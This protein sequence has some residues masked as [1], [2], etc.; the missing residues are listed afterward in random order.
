MGSL[1][2]YPYLMLRN[3]S[4]ITVSNNPLLSVSADDRDDSTNSSIIDT[5]E[6]AS[7]GLTSV[8]SVL[9]YLPKLDYLDL[10]NNGMHGNIPDWIWRNMS[11]LH[12]QHNLFT[13]V[14]QLPAYTFIDVLD[15][16]FNKLG[17]SVPFP[18]SGNWFDY[19][20]NIFS[21]IPSLDFIRQF[22]T[23]TKMNLSNNELSSPVPYTECQEY[24]NIKILDLS[25]VT[26]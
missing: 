1:D 17:G 5:L 16:S 11:G 23:A 14:G 4:G 24:D 22:R 2:L 20:N 15:L 3:L 12:L 19:S 21:S 13:K 7:C 26:N 9:K 10:S 6:L 25:I 18:F 8:P